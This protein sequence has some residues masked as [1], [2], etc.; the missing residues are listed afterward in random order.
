VYRSGNEF[1]SVN[2]GAMKLHTCIIEGFPN[3]RLSLV[4]ATDRRRS[5]RNVCFCINRVIQ[6]DQVGGVYGFIS[7]LELYSGALFP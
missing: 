3:K 7:V 4:T 5:C 1:A 6:E 2:S